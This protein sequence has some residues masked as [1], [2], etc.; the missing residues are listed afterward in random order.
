MNHYKVIRYQA[1]G[2]RFYADNKKLTR[3]HTVSE[4]DI[5][6]DSEREALGFAMDLFGDSSLSSNWK[7]ELRGGIDEDKYDSSKRESLIAML[8]GVGKR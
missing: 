6:A 4:C 2:D 7:V 3:V 5:F 8:A 1:E